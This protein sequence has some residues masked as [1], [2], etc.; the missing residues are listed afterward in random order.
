MM[1]GH[2]S[3]LVA[4]ALS[5]LASCGN[6]DRSL[7][8]RVSTEEPAPSVVAS[9]ARL[10]EARGFSITIDSDHDTA[11]M[12]AAVRDAHTDLA[13]IEEPLSMIPGVVALTPLYPSILHVLYKGTMQPATLAEVV[14]GH[15]VYAGPRESTAFRLLNQLTASQAVAADE[16]RVLDNPWQIEPDV[17]FIFGGL[18]PED[19]LRQLAGYRLFSFGDV[20]DL[21]RGSIADG[22]ALKYPNVDTFVLPKGLYSGLHDQPIVTLAIR[23]LLIAREGLTSA[24]AYDIVATLLEHTQEIAFAYPLVTEQLNTEFAPAS[25]TLPLHSGARRYFE[26][27]K[28]GFMER[29]VEVLALSAT[30]L[31]ALGSGVVSIYRRRQQLKK[32]RID[33]YYGKVLDMRRAVVAADGVEELVELTASVTAVQHEVFDL[34]INERIA[35]DSA[36]TIFLDLSNRVLEEIVARVNSWS[37]R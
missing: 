17:Y 26:R 23:T 28:P 37:D 31:L 14:R 10:L 19:S 7:S 20:A 35:A 4:L 9:I 5:V 22:I 36:L 8:F 27:D 12:I 16:Y 18:L 33:V 15:T 32:D 30:F 3:I 25:L 6:L 1:S 29:Y 24:T 13:I 11:N 34:L 2:R 21:G